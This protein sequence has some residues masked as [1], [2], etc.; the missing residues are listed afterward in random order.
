MHFESPRKLITVKEA[1][2]LTSLSTQYFYRLISNNKITCYRFGRSVR[3][4]IEAIEDMKQPVQ[5]I[6]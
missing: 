6:S 4:P 5:N 2:D 1:A 3:I